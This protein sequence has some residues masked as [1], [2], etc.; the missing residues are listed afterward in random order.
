MGRFLD[1]GH[2]YFPV[3]FATDNPFEGDAQ[4]VP[5]DELRLED[6]DELSQAIDEME[7]AFASGAAERRT[8]L[9]ARTA[10]LC[11]LPLL[12]EVA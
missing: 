7:A 12:E 6:I 8:A 10:A 11:P 1:P 3:L 5:A 4:S 9:K 2:V